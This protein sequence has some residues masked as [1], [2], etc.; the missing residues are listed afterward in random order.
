M[1]S[2]PVPSE[3]VAGRPPRFDFAIAGRHKKITEA[4]YF[5]AQQRG[6]VPGHELDDWLAAEQK[7]D[8]AAEPLPAG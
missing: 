4:A 6:F 3:V 5:K 7:V 2:A 1:N 8:K